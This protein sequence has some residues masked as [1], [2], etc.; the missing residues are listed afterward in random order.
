MAKKL[1]AFVMILF[2]TYSMAAIPVHQAHS[3]KQNL[4]IDSGVFVGGRDHGPLTLLNVRHSIKGK[5]ERLVF[6][7]GQKAPADGVERPGFF[8]ISI[9]SQPQRIV[10][11]FENVTEAKVTT[12]Q[13]E[14][15][16][17]KSPYL[18]KVALLQDFFHKDLTLEFP[19]RGPAQIEVFELVSTGKPGRIVVDVTSP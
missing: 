3:E 11:E 7:L 13:I 15:L 19:L 5:I 2:S 4:Y 8:H 1:F 10:M 17:L 12:G 9:Q 6:D 14:K 16:F 18:S